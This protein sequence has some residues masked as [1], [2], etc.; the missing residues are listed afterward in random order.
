MVGEPNKLTIGENGWSATLSPGCRVLALD[1]RNRKV[2]FVVLEFKDRVR[3]LDWGVRAIARR[4]A[5][6]TVVAINRVIHLIQLHSVRTVVLC[7]SRFSRRIVQEVASGIQSTRVKV[8][9]VDAA[10]V[11][12][13]FAE[14]RCNNKHQTAVRI[15]A[16]FGELAWKLPAQRR[17][18]ESEHY[19]ATIFDAAAV[20]VY[21]LSCVEHEQRRSPFTR[22]LT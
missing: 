21:F 14:Q 16:L 18:W 15:T 19:N 1:L 22:P 13:L 10:N 4:Q 9:V 7:K 11:R 6:P 5:N 2:G 20:A 17:P 12:T 8:W 3:L